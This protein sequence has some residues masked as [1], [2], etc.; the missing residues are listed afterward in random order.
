MGQMQSN[1]QPITSIGNNG[2]PTVV[3]FWAPWCENCKQ[4]APT[5]YQVEQEF[6]V[7]VNFVMING[8]D[9]NAWPL[10]EAFGVDAIPHLALVE[11]DGPVDTAL[12]GRVPKAWLEQD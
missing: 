11:S 1:S 9:P 7:D 10:I 12:I 3:D 8:D 2:K 6:K 5:L 4:M